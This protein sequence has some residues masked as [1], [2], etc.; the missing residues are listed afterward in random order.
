MSVDEDDTLCTFYDN[1]SNGIFKIQ[2]YIW[3]KT[4]IDSIS[5]IKMDLKCF[6]V[7]VLEDYYTW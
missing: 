1:L 7:A 3:P 2:P 4:L 5:L 6:C